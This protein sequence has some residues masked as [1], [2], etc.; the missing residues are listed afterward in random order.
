MIDLDIAFQKLMKEKKE[1]RI[2][3]KT[4]KETTISKST[5]CISFAILLFF[6]GIGLSKISGWLTIVT[7]NL[8]LFFWILSLKLSNN[9]SNSKK[10]NQIAVIPRSIH[11]WSHCKASSLDF[12]GL[13]FMVMSL[14]GM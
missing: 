1:V 13:P 8:S 14:G 2:E 11:S 7:W 5:Y 4:Q 3:R 12:A 10:N 6:I 9:R